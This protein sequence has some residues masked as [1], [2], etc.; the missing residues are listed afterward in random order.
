M[1]LLTAEE[2]A[3]LL[4]KSLTWVYHKWQELEIPFFKVGNR[5]LCAEGDFQAWLIRQRD[6]EPK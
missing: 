5:L 3:Q 6:K 4:R 2:I 1:K